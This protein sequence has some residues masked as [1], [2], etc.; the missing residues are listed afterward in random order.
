MIINIITLGC[1]KNLVDSEY[2]LR[3]FHSNGH[4]VF[5][6]AKDIDADVVILNTCGFILDAKEES[7]ETILRYAAQ[8]KSGRL[9]KLIVMGCLS[10]R[11]MSDLKREIPE[12]DHFFGV[13]DH[14][15]IVRSVGSEY[16]HDQIN[17]RFVTTPSHYAYLKVS[18]GCNRQCAFCAIPGIR[19]P[20]RSRSLEALLDEA[21]N[22]AAGGA[23]E[24][25]L[26]A[27]DLTSYG[28][29][30]NGRKLLP[31]LLRRLSKL[32]EIDWIRLHYAYPTG[33]P[34][35]VI[36]LMALDPK[37]CKYMDMP[38][39]HINSR[40][41]SAM[42]R[43]HKRDK[44]E[45]LLGLF[46]QK[47]P[48]VAIRTTVLTGFPGETEEE[49]DELYTFLEKFRFERLGVFPYSHEEDTPAAGLTDDVPAVVKQE[50]ADR[51]MELQ[52]QISLEINCEKVGQTL[53]VL[54]DKEEDDYYT[55]RT[56]HDSPE[57]D[58]EVLV[59]KSSSLNTGKFYQVLIT[60]AEE[61][62][63]YGTV[64]DPL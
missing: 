45:K 8:K 51:I 44:L 55:G 38:I 63:L 27:Q 5:H 58:N 19:G 50:R 21:R 15:E 23:R 9:S 62:D 43:G 28:M 64:A 31:E 14:K 20:Q 32:N 10:E 33:F 41:L 2:I 57:V 26:V 61:F 49:F 13:W 59:S 24:L 36:D 6:D 1:S 37:I 22:L 12:V 53:R 56:E 30:L 7:I 54:I 42:N 39:Q 18:E 35:E 34:E 16:Y 3:Q 29:D 25:I 60:A 17:N 46:R 47:V 4:Q 52:Q 11:Y 48:G 40:I